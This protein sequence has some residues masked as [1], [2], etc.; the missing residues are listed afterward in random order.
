MKSRTLRTLTALAVIIIVAIGFVTNFGIGTVSAVGW[1][2]ISLLCPLGALGTMLA[3]QMMI[4]RAV[5]SLIFAILFI[6][7][8]ARAF[9][10]WLCPVPLVQKIR[11]LFA[12]KPSKKEAGVPKAS[13]D[14]TSEGSTPL[15]ESTK[16]R[17]SPALTKAEQKALKKSCSSSDC[18]S[19]AEKQGRALDSRHFI[20]GGSLLSAAIFG[21]P[22]FCVICPIGLS[23]GTILLVIRLFSGGDVTWS[24]IAIPFILIAEVVLFKKW[25]GKLCPLS[26]FMSLI[27]KLNVT[28]RPT[29][30]DKTCI[31]TAKGRECGLCAKA[32]PEGIDPRHPEQGSAWSECTKCRACVDACPTASIKMPLLPQKK[33]TATPQGGDTEAVLEFSENK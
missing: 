3:K 10:G 20:L 30:D 1:G 4:P 23:F 24:L 26:A 9:C 7:V 12:K 8:F 25:C 32:C 18:A 16:A 17:L 29:I 15:A 13:E 21:F 11:G 14:I 2:E 27:G 19:C 5:I 28:F 6:I 31:E 22:V 33:R